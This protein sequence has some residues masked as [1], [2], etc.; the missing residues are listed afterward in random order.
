VTEGEYLAAEYALGLLEGEELL[1]ARARAA[2]DPAFA[3]AVAAWQARLVPLFDEFDGLAPAPELWA[4]IEAELDALAPGGEVI[5]LRRKVRRWQWLTAVSAVAAALLAV[6][7]TIFLAQPIAPP[8]SPAPLVASIPIT[9]TPL[10][11]GLTYLPAS[12]ELLVAADGLTADGVHDHQL[13]VIS[14]AGTPIPLGLVTPGG[15][16]RLTVPEATTGELQHGS[17]IAISREPLGGSPGPLPSGP[18]VA[19]GTLTII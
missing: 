4:R 3:Q 5:A 11:L 10:R 9:G 6:V 1:Q 2:G 7:T 16:S 18:V 14:A 12:E 19:S 8:T 13:W 17:T 15:S